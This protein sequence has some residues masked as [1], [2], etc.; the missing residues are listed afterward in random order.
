M[1]L[2]DGENALSVLFAFVFFF[3]FFTT[4][5][6]LIWDWLMMRAGLAEA[7]AAA[8]ALLVGVVCGVAERVAGSTL[9]TFGSE[10]FGA[11]SF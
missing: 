3:V 1:I 9:F 2:S 7:A 4:R 8:G 6:V 5:F 10:F 11:V